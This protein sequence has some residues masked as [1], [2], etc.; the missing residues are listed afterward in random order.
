[1]G[2]NPT[3]SAI[4]LGAN[5]LKNIEEIIKFVKD[6]IAFHERQALKY[7]QDSRRVLLHKQTAN[8][9]QELCDFLDQTK[10]HENHSKKNIPNLSLSW[11]EIQD[12][13]DELLAELS[14]T[15]SDKLDYSIVSLI[16]ENGG[17]ATLDRVIVSL[18]SLTGEIFK[19]ASLNARLY[20]MVQKGMIYSI[21]GK[22]GVYSTSP[23]VDE[24]LQ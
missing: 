23:A 19:R 2:S 20:R 5:D 12:L 24:N 1:M 16:D 22:K 10:K 7:K 18:Y 17:V 15:E 13:P 9:F 6:Q 8:K 21:Q 4:H 14:F 3:P 11:N